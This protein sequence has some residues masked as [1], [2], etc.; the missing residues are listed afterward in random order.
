MKKLILFTIV[1]ITGLTAQ[2]QKNIK[3]WYDKP[4]AQWVEALPLG[5]GRIGAMV[6]G[7]VEDELIQLNEGSLWSGGPM[8]KM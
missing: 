3:L 7:S 5:N 1:V 2:A 8:K 6:F 4:A